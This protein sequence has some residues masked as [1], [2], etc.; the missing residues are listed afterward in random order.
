MNTVLR[1]ADKKLGLVCHVM[2]SDKNLSV[3]S[4]LHVTVSV[5]AAVCP[6]VFI[7]QFVKIVEFYF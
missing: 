6:N 1:V 4:S 2:L 7:F 3:L 5:S